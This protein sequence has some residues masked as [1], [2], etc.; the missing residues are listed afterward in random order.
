MTRAFYRFYWW[1]QRWI[2]PGLRYC[3]EVYEDALADTVK[4]DTRWLDLGCG[5]NFLPQWR[6]EGRPV[7]DRDRATAVSCAL[8]WERGARLFRVHNVALAREALSIA[9]ATTNPA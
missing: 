9:S 5:H 2:A 6:A 4:G 7:E 3:L 8:A 1:L